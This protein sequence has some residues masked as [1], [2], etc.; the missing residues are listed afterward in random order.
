MLLADSTWK[1]PIS[2]NRVSLQFACGSPAEVDETYKKLIEA[3]HQS[4]K[5]P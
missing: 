4:F 5:T 2:K 3:G 1:A